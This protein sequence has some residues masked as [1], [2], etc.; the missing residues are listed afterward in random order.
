MVRIRG[1]TRL[2]VV[3]AATV[4]S[5]FLASSQ[6]LGRGETPVCDYLNNWE[7]DDSPFPNDY[8]HT[9]DTE[10]PSWGDPFGSP[11]WS[12][13]ATSGMPRENAHMS[14]ES[15]WMAEHYIGEFYAH[16]ECEAR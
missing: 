16:E 4:A 13:A 14:W 3:G 9:R 11:E 10:A 12:L 8:Y 1:T 15:G 2:F 5:V 7:E 6:V